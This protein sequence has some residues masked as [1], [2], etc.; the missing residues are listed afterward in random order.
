MSYCR[1]SKTACGGLIPTR[2]LGQAA[3]FDLRVQIE[4]AGADEPAEVSPQFDT[5]PPS[6][7]LEPPPATLRYGLEWTRADTKTTK[8]GT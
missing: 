8:K 2:S 6:P 5:L 3:W 7:G 1:P 4:K